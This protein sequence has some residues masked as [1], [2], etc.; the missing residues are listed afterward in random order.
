MLKNGILHPQLRSLMGRL[1][2]MD[3]LVIADAGLPVPAGW[4][5]SISAGG[6]AIRPIWMC[7]RSS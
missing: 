2:H 5:G 1:R 3:T 7:S 4:N 6:R